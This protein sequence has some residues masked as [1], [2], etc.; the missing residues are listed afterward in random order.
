M[1]RSHL[2]RGDRASFCDGS[3]EWDGMT[4]GMMAG[5]M[6]VNRGVIEQKESGE[7]GISVALLRSATGL[8]HAEVCSSDGCRRE[9]QS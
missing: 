6:A 5:M 2:G 8:E 4:A 3:Y 1:M 9:I 7:S